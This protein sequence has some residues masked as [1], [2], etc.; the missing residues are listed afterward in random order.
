MLI[1]GI[2]RCSS[3]IP[4]KALDFFSLSVSFFDGTVYLRY[5]SLL[6][7]DVNS[8]VTTRNAFRLRGD[9]RLEA[10]DIAQRRLWTHWLSGLIVLPL[11][12][13]SL[14]S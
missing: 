7:P 6:M 14:A 8:L 1:V 12:R 13:E 5:Y 2:G 10:S 4:E 9:L 11:F 3:T